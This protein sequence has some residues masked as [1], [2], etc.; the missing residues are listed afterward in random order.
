MWGDFYT[1]SGFSQSKVSQGE[2]NYAYN[3]DI[4][5]DVANLHNYMG[6]PVDALGNELFKIIVPNTIPEPATI[7]L[8]GSAGLW[9]LKHKK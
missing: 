3:V 5:V 1:K 9:I 7:T 2:W 6:T 4:G 8:L